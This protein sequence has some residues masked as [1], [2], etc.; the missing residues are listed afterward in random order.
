MCYFYTPVQCIT[1]C[2]HWAAVEKNVLLD[3]FRPDGS[4]AVWARCDPGAWSAA[5][6]R[7]RDAQAA[8]APALASSSSSSS[9]AAAARPCFVVPRASAA[10]WVLA[11]HD[12]GGGC[13]A[14]VGVE[15]RS[16]DRSIELE[17]LEM[18]YN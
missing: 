2:L 16:I 12:S 10:R 13:G 14:L 7:A 4:D 3:S 17:D 11:P 6:D 5:V 1:P 8:P 18:A 9:A 15:V